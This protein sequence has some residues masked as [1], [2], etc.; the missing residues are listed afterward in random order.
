MEKITIMTPNIDV[1]P[2][3]LPKDDSNMYKFVCKGRFD[4]LEESL[5]TCMGEVKESL[6]ELHSRLFIGNGTESL[7]KQI[8]RAKIERE[9][10]SERINELR[11]I[12]RWGIGVVGSVTVF[13][14]GRVLYQTGVVIMSHIK[15]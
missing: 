8:L 12:I 11:G 7:E 10:L 6:D 14:L 2:A 5:K 13:L 4:R 3:D 1:T 9:H 15:W